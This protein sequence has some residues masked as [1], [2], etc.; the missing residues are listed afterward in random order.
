MITKRCRSRP[1][2]LSCCSSSSAFAPLSLSLSS[3]PTTQAAAAP[4]APLPAA[5]V[6]SL[7][8]AAEMQ[9][10]SDVTQLI[11]NTPMVYLNRVGKGLPGRVAAK[12][13]C[14]VS[15]LSFSSS[16]FVGGARL[17]LPSF[18]SSLRSSHPPLFPPPNKK[19]PRPKTTPSPPTARDHGAVLLREGPHRPRHDRGRREERQNRARENDARRAHQR[20]HRHRSRLHR[21]RKG[22]QA[23]ADDAGV[24]VAGAAHPA[25][26]VRGGAGEFSYL[27][28]SLFGFMFLLSSSRLVLSFSRRRRRPK[29]KPKRK[30]SPPKT[31]P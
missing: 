28:L 31:P 9:V 1:F 7:D 17:S 11:G 5:R 20:Q 27:C 30:H 23:R 24:H 18:S 26:R 29:H 2:S 13:S 15:V 21:G 25:A 16:P 8:K 19:N 22:L 14:F 10:A 4:R 12:V 6:A 3:R